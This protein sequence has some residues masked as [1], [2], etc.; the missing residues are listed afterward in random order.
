MRIKREKEVKIKVDGDPFLDRR[1]KLLPCQIQ[2]IKTLRANR[3]TFNQIAEIFPTCTM[4]VLIKQSNNKKE[5]RIK[6]CEKRTLGSY[7]KYWGQNGKH[8]KN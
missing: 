8:S 5:K 6:Q 4:R 3:Y 7:S 2:L 1:G